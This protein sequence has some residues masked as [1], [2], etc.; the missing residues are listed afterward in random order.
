M[1]LLPENRRGH[2]SDS[3]N[4]IGSPAVDFD[5]IF[6]GHGFLDIDHFFSGGDGGRTFP[7]S[8]CFVREIENIGSFF[9]DNTPDSPE[10][11]AHD[12]NNCFAGGGGVDSQF[13]TVPGT[14]DGEL[15]P[16]HT[17]LTGLFGGKGD[18][19]EFFRLEPGMFFQRRPGTE[20]LAAVVVADNIETAAAGS[21]KGKLFQRDLEFHMPETFAF[22]GT[23]DD[24]RTPGAVRFF[25]S[26]GLQPVQKI[27]HSS[28]GIDDDVTDIPFYIGK[29]SSA[30]LFFQIIRSSRTL[31]PLVLSFWAQTSFP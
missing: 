27:G 31:L 17:A 3:R 13:H 12:F 14:G 6:T 2:L 11:A 1:E 26:P 18:L 28:F 10:L 19:P 15:L 21:V 4:K 23:C 9:K 25:R 20:F 22:A 5:K 16:G 30:E 29:K 24:H 8:A 7:A